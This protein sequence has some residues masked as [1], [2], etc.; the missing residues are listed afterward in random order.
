[1][2]PNNMFNINV[3]T[4]RCKIA[5]GVVFLISNFNTTSLLDIPKPNGL[6]FILISNL[7]LNVVI[8]ISLL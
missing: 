5:K 8:P 7:K 1:M 6:Y 3:D 2:I 4:E